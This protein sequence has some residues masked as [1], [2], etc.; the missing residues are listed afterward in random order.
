MQYGRIT[1]HLRLA[2][3]QLTIGK[4][5]FRWNLRENGK[6]LVASLYN[7]S[8]LSESPVYD[9]KKIRKIK[10]LLKIKFLHGIYVEGFFLL[11]IILL[12]RIDMAVKYVF[13]S[14][15]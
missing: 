11:K 4:D 2:N 7:A 8:I 6:F 13:F 10:Y 9:N 14:T 12:R 15:R 1:L 3:T 5:I